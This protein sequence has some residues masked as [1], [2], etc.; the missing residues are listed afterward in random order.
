MKTDAAGASPGRLRRHTPQLCCHADGGPLNPAW[1][2]WL[3]GW[4]VGWTD[5]APPGAAHFDAW[6]RQHGPHAAGEP[7]PWFGI[8]PATLA[9]GAPGFVPRMAQMKVPHRA[10]RI[11]ALGNGQVPRCV[12]QAWA[13]LLDGHAANDDRADAPRL[14]AGGDP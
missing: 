7:D 1:V 13:V 2:E 6:A 4:P 5:L 3:M 14:A 9:P 10:K 12:V 11:E 8:D